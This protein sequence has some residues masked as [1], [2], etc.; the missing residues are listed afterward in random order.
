LREGRR[1][2]A[3]D[4]PIEREEAARERLMLGLR[5]SRGVEADEIERW[6]A[7]AGDP[8][9]GDDYAAWLDAGVLARREGR[10]RFTERGF[11]VS[12]EVLCRFV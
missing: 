4:R 2:L 3:L 9:L 1:P 5:L 10:V 12:N 6:I 7:G 11:L 8:L